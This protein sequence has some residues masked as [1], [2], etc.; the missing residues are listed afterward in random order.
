MAWMA[1]WA[2]IGL[3]KETKPARGRRD[4]DQATR[5]RNLPKHL[6][7]FV[8]LS[9]KTLLEITLPKEAKVWARS[10]SVYSAGR[11][12]GREKRDK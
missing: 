9:I 11:K 7:K 3:S 1:T 10:E 5:E 8:F 2:E 4:D 6:L 12:R